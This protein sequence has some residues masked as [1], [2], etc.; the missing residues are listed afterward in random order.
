MSSHQS[1]N[2]LVPADSRTHARGA[3]AILKSGIY[4][5]NQAS[6]VLHPSLPSPPGAHLL[7]QSP[8][9][10]PCPAAAPGAGHALTYGTLEFGS[11]LH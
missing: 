2:Q 6:S 7:L 10:A 11:M 5:G 3:A 1:I 9:P 8:F 4:K